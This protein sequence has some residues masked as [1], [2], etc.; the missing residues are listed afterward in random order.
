MRG[1]KRGACTLMVTGAIV[2]FINEALTIFEENVD[3][4]NRFCKMPRKFLDNTVFSET[5]NLIHM[6]EFHLNHLH[7]DHFYK[8][9]GPLP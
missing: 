8:W 2:M 9:F 5:S 6:R 4:K 7:K 3:G 1:I